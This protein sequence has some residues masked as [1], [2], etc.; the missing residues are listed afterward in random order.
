MSHIAMHEAIDGEYAD[1]MEA[2]TDE[3]FK[4]NKG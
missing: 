3:Q 4:G 1:W 2:V